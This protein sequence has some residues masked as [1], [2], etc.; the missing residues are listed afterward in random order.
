M[1]AVKHYPFPQA[2]TNAMHMSG[3]GIKDL[4][5]TTGI[6]ENKLERIISGN[7]L[8]DNK[9]IE[10]ISRVFGSVPVSDRAF[11]SIQSAYMWKYT[12]KDN[13]KCTNCGKVG[14]DWQKD[15]S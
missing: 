14:F 9:S 5:T 6:S 1:K 2:L 11:H 12:G 4:S 10:K 7:R 8:P 3:I 13:S 15:L